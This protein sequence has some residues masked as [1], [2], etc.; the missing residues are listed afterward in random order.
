MLSKWQRDLLA[1]VPTARIV[2][3]PDANLFMF[4]TNEA[5]II[6]EVRT[7]ATLLK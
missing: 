7:F 3:L 5:D 4:L 1:G 6:R 2:E